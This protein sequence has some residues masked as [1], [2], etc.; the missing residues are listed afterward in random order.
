MISLDEAYMLL[1]KHLKSVNLK[2]HCLA[3]SVIMRELAKKLNENEMHWEIIG[4]LH[5][6]DFDD[7][8]DD[9]ERHTLITER[10]LSDYDF[11]LE[12]I[13]A[14]KAHNELTGIKRET[15]LEFALAA[16]ETITGLIIA[17][18]KVY[19]DK[20]ISSVRV[21]SIKK[22]MKEKAFA[23]NVNRDTIRECERIGISLDDFIEL[24]IKAMADIEEKLL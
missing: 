10:I 16:C 23:R 7:T 21:K 17:T 2:K 1:D 13:R 9:P 5:D 24:S 4:L 6:L 14:I 15:T 8:R 3:T 20:R 12:Y 22:R 18:A 11:P 19:P